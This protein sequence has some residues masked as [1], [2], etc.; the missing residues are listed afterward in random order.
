MNS[1]IQTH[2][3]PVQAVAHSVHRA[4]IPENE[5]LPGEE[6]APEEDPVPHPDPVVREPDEFPNAPMK[7]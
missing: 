1:A 7:M 2:A 6:P 3:S 5:P 4:P